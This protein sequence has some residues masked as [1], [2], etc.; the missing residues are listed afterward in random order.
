M[1][2]RILATLSGAVV[3]GGTQLAAAPSAQAQEPVAGCATQD[4]FFFQDASAFPLTM[5]V[6]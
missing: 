6:D 2:R 4:G 3:L 1:K 5:A